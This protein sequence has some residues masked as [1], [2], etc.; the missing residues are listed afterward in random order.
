MMFDPEEIVTLGGA[1]MTLRGAVAKVIEIPQSYRNLATIFRQE[2][3]P[4]ILDIDAIEAIA[5]SP[6]FALPANR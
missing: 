4:S 3:H 5:L 2:G 6:A 1:K